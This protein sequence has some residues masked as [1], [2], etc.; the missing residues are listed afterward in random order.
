MRKGVV[1]MKRDVRLMRHLSYGPATGKDILK[2]IFAREGSNDKTRRRVMM[3]RLVKLEEE[4]LIQRKIC[5]MNKDYLYRLT[6]EA[7]PIVAEQAGL[8]LTSIWVSFKDENMEHDLHVAKLARKIV[9][10]AAESPFF[11]LRYIAMECEMRRFKKITRGEYFPDFSFSL[12]ADGHPCTFDV[13]V[14]LGTISRNDFMGK[15]RYFSNKILVVT[16]R[17]K[18][19]GLLLNYIRHSCMS[20][21]IYL[22]TLQEFYKET[23]VDC[24]WMTRTREDA[25]T[26]AGYFGVNTP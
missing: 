8:E 23:L 4:G 5:R 17:E 6:R 24:R 1:L 20:K 2:N 15:M 7:A 10:E 16:T 22:T 9:Q 3:R 25:V 26:L 14:D 11:H 18:R 19:L 12:Q 13:E 21:A